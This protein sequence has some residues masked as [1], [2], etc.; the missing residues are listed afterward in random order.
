[1]LKNEHIVINT[2]TRWDSEPYHA[3]H[4]IA[5]ELRKHNKI[6][7]IESPTHALEIIRFIIQGDL[8]E[9]FIKRLRQIDD[10]FFIYRP[11]SIFPSLF[12]NKL[13]LLTNLINQRFIAFQI[14]RILN[15]LDMGDDVI[16]WNFNYTASKI[17]KYVDNK[18][19]LHYCCDE[20]NLKE[21]PILAEVEKQTVE[22]V[23][24]VFCV[25][26]LLKQKMSKINK[27]TFLSYLGVDTGHKKIKDKFLADKASTEMSKIKQ[28]I[29][30]YSGVISDRLDFEILD[31]IAR[32]NKN[33]NFVF[34][35]LVGNINNFKKRFQKFVESH[36]NVYYLG[37]KDPN[38]FMYYVDH[39]DVAL[40]PFNQNLSLIKVLTACLKMFQYLLCG[41]PFVVTKVKGLIE[42]P[43]DFYYTAE[44]SEEY[45]KAIEIAL[46]TDTPL[47]RKERSEF[48]LKS[49]WENR[50]E[51]ISNKI[52]KYI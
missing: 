33:W 31:N 23:D 5:N 48:G 36:E 43:E 35:G 22:N 41:C 14:T 19:S 20:E 52:E 27:N 21:N 1:M 44:T 49:S 38:E 32:R 10:N 3:R 39:F 4:Y 45:T 7:F 9:I 30:G 26:H 42:L 28:P 13:C 8:K 6:L 40:A 12:V 51:D 17:P 16:L 46:K 50:I 37:N 34:I 2:V 15:K 29:I 18:I 25:S 11:Y 24:L 47:L